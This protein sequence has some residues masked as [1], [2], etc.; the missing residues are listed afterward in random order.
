MR[1]DPNSQSSEAIQQANV[2]DPKNQP[3][4][5]TQLDPNA[6][7]GVQ[8]QLSTS[9]SQVA[10]LAQQAA[11]LPDVRTDRVDALKQAVH[12]GSFNPTNDQ[13]AAAIYSDASSGSAN[14]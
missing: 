9:S 5:K 4:P 2:Q 11:S 12:D 13:V 14:K 8:V 6:T 3:A 10:T 1:I 7:S